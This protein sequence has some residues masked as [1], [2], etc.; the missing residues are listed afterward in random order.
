MRLVVNALALDP[1]HGGIAAF[2]R[3]LLLALDR[4][5]RVET[6]ALASANASAGLAVHRGLALPSAEG[7][8]LSLTCVRWVAIAPP[9]PLFEDV[10][11]PTVLDDLGADVFLSPLPSL[12]V[13]SPCPGIMTVHDLIPFTHPELASETA[14]ALGERLESSLRVAA[15]VLVPSSAT[16]RELVA[17]GYMSE[18]VH[19]ATQPV[20]LPADQARAADSGVRRGVLGIGPLERRRDWT[21]LVQAAAR[22]DPV[23]AVTIV[24][25]DGDERTRLE[26]LAR[27]L[28]VVLETKGFLPAPELA[29]RLESTAVLC[30]PSLAE[31][32]CR[33]VLEGFRAGAPVVASALPAIEEVA[34]GGALLV[35]PGDVAAWAR[36]LERVIAEPAV[37]DRLV[38]TAAARARD[39]TLERLR[40]EL[41]AALFAVAALGATA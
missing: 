26:A 15:G 11:L 18:R 12:P 21:T 31:G 2:T 38:Q 9:G 36:A 27:E 13:V 8:A 30:V 22:L 10:E 33:P 24:G 28:G 7:Q 17:G 29:D 35:P 23:P 20:L 6:L 5:D 37:G 3:E 40:D 39:F 25:H 1:R 32:F 41:L 14:R 4:T 16:A 34:G 19:V